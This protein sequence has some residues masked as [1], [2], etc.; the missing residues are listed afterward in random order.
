MLIRQGEYDH[1]D[2]RF[3]IRKTTK[4]LKRI[5]PGSNRKKKSNADSITK[6]DWEEIMGMRRETYQQ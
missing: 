2:Q 4:Q 1:E 5:A 6:R 3:F